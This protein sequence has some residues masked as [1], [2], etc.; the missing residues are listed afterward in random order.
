MR[1]INPDKPGKVLWNLVPLYHFGR[2][3]A[4]P[5]GKIFKSKLN[6]VTIF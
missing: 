6:A 3:S 5:D 4:S 1:K 2:L